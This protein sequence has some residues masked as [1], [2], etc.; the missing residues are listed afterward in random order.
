M[1]VSKD[2]M[3]CRLR[4]RPP[5]PVTPAKAGVQGRAGSTAPTQRRA[6]GRWIPGQARND[7]VGGWDRLFSGQVHLTSGEQYRLFSKQ[8]S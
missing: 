6:G 2:R 1:Q 8:D 3:P 4:P 5:R 7:G